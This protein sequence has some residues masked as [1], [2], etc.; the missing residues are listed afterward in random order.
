MESLCSNCEKQGETRLML[1]NIPFFKDVM[2]VSFTCPHCGYRNN[3]IQ[4]A[5]VLAEFGHRITV[6]IASKEDLNRDIC[7]GEFATTF[8]PELGL[9]VPFNQK[10]YMSTLEGF[11]TG[12]KEDLL[13]QQPARRV[14]LV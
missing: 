4:N 8:V 3:E 12:F 1:T 11:L 2:V 7:R 10:G 5:G 9:E 14:S 6:K 13:M